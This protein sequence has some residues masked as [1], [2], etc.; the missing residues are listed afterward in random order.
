[1]CG[2]HL[3]QDPSIVMLLLTYGFSS[4]Y[5]LYVLCSC[6]HMEA[7]G[8]VVGPEIKLRSSGFQGK[9]LS[10]M[11][12]PCCHF[13]D[14][15]KR[16]LLKRHQMLNDKISF[17]KT[18]STPYRQDGSSGAQSQVHEYTARK[19]NPGL[20]NTQTNSLSLKCVQFLPNPTADINGGTAAAPATASC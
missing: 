3:R 13:V 18:L 20:M 4:I 8:Q 14:R 16:K 12:H 10:S 15:D 9:C 2:S 19:W 11:S 1:M 7:G 6:I 5:L 17:T